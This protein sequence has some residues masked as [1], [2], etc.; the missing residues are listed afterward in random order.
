MRHTAKKLI[1]SVTVLGLAGCNSLFDQH[2]N[3]TMKL[4][5]V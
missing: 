4:Q 2:V 3:V 1:L 5:T